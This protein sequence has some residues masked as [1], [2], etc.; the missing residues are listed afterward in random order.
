[1]RAV[2][3]IAAMLALAQCVSAPDRRFD[4]G[5]EENALVIIGVA[6]AARDTSPQYVMLWRRLNEDGAFTEYGARTILEPV[7]GA[8]DSVRVRDIPGEF[9]V[10][11]VEP[12]VYALD[13]A[14]AVIHDRRVD[15]IAQGVI[16]GPERPAFEVRAGEGI[17]L[18]IWEMDLEE[19][20]AVTRLWRLE[21]RDLRAVLREAD[22][23][24]G[25]VR[26]RQTH[27]RSV[28]C[29]PRRL[30]TFSQR[31]AC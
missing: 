2:L 29:Q 30:T 18:G 11:A 14:F 31:E 20:R 23:I 4:V 19:T 22:R 16:E 27:T 7:T 10:V 28:A 1:M 21:E 9:F 3:A 25:Q 13:S 24:R 8:R 17:Y 26:V 5:A 15:Y 6:E 12:G